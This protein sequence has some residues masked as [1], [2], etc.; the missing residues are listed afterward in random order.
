[1]VQV[2]FGDAL[3]VSHQMIEAAK[4]PTPPSEVTI[5]DHVVIAFTW[6][7]G[8]NG[9]WKELFTMQTTPGSS[10][11]TFKTNTTQFYS[12]NIL[13]SSSGFSLTSGSIGSGVVPAPTGGVQSVANEFV[14]KMANTIFQREGAADLLSNEAELVADIT[15]DWGTGSDGKL[16]NDIR[17]ALAPANYE[18][19]KTDSNPAAIVLNTLKTNSSTQNRFNS[20]VDLEASTTDPNFERI[21]LQSEDEL[22]FSVTI[23]A[24]AHS[25]GTNTVA[26]RKYKFIIT[27]A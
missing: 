5:D 1:M 27:L 11:I 10:T 26:A 3:S 6:T 20:S 18:N 15:N 4:L 22:I 19:D 14:R 25:I 17:D 13:S 23:N 9:S 24:A 16:L 7:D 21:P 12:A 2:D 8:T